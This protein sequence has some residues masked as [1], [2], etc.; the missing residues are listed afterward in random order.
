MNTGVLHP[1]GGA[2][3]VEFCEFRMNM[4]S[5]HTMSKTQMKQ[6]FHPPMHTFRGEYVTDTP[7]DQ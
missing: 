2:R 3:P 4:V 5:I 7:N 6:L 1:C